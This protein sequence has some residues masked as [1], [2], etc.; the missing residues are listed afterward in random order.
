VPRERIES[1][2]VPSRPQS[3]NATKRL[4]RAAPWHDLNLGRKADPEIRGVSGFEALPN[5]PSANQPARPKEA[6]V[7]SSHPPPRPAEAHVAARETGA[8]RGALVWSC[9]GGASPEGR[10]HLPRERRCGRRA[11]AVAGRGSCV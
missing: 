7:R 6:I 11:S 3:D 10:P 1:A 2:H 5:W 8:W 9:P 4:P